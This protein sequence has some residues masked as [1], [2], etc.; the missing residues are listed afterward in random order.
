MMVLRMPWHGGPKYDVALLD[1]DPRQLNG[2]CLD[3]R[4]PTHH[5][6]GHSLDS[7][8]RGLTQNYD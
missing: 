8:I 6:H 1:L 4:P 7:S 3:L 2:R 5:R